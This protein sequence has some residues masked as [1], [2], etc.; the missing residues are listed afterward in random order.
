MKSLITY[1]THEALGAYV[2]AAKQ[3]R[4]QLLWD[5]NRGHRRGCM[6]NDGD[7]DGDD[8]SDNIHQT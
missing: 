1:T 4:R 5:S 2:Q 6:M 7:D 3:P 8:V